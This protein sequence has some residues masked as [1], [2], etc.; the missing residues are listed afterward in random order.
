MIL[1]MRKMKSLNG[2]RKK[3]SDE[4]GHPSVGAEAFWRHLGVPVSSAP[5]AVGAIFKAED[6]AE[7]PAQ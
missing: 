2:L 5:I 3:V 6:D 4:P 1:R 7:G